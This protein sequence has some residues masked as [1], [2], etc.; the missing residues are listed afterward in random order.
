MKAFLIILIFV[1]IIQGM[2]EKF[3]LIS[4][5]QAALEHDFDPITIGAWVDSELF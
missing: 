1:G 3:M 5:Q 2:S 4:I